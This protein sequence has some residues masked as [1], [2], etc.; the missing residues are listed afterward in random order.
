MPNRASGTAVIIIING[1]VR[2]VGIIPHDTDM[3]TSWLVF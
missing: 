1:V 2:N 3:F